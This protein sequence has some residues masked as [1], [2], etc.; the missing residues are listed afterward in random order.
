[1]NDV[2][3]ENIES[4]IQDYDSHDFSPFQINETNQP[5]P[6]GIKEKSGGLWSTKRYEIIEDVDKE[7][8]ESAY[9]LMTKYSKL[10]Q[11][12]KRLTEGEQL[13]IDSDCRERNYAKSD[14]MKLIK[15]LQSTNLHHTS[16]HQTNIAIL[17]YYALATRAIRTMQK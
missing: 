11:K 6:L 7:R 13:Q 17:N 15:E 12:G 5:S 4:K 3:E 10:Q 2:Y 9:E 1:M 14:V 8:T 16:Q